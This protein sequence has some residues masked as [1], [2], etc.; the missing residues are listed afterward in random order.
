[1]PQATTLLIPV[2][3]IDA[4]GCPLNEQHVFRARIAMKI[5][6]AAEEAIIDEGMIARLFAATLQN[7][8]AGAKILPFI[9]KVDLPN[10]LERGRRLARVLLESTPS[11]FK[12]VLL[13]QALRSPAVEEIAVQ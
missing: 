12:R 7:K 5:L 1:L 8:P 13:G 6:E 9:N 4:L 10:G 11:I 2:V 3:G